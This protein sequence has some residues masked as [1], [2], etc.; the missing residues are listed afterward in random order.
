M[1]AA[2]HVSQ[3]I[4]RFSLLAVDRLCHGL[5]M[6]IRPGPHELHERDYRGTAVLSILALT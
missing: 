1:N 2:C 4:S 6:A 5:L 3:S